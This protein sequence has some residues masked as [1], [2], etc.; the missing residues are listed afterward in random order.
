MRV[1]PQGGN[2]RGSPAVTISD[3]GSGGSSCVVNPS[4]ASGLPASC[5]GSPVMGVAASGIDGVAS[6][7]SNVAGFRNIFTDAGAVHGVIFAALPG[8]A[9]SAPDAVRML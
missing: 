6:I 5:G 9:W 8:L 1:M 7:G 3:G 4:I 2:S